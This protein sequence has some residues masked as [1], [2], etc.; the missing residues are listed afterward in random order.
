MAFIDL[1]VFAYA[2]AKSIQASICIFYVQ[3]EK[4]FFQQKAG[5]IKVLRSI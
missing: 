1:R 4:L 5:Y 2:R 3:K